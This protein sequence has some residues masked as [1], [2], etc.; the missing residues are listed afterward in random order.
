MRSCHG[1]LMYFRP[2]GHDCVTSSA[3]ALAVDARDE[4]LHVGE[5]ERRARIRIGDAHGVAR[6]GRASTSFEAALLPHGDV[7]TTRDEERAG[8]R[9]GVERRRAGGELRERLS[10][11]VADLHRVARDR[12]DRRTPPEQEDL[13]APDHRAQV[14]RRARRGAARS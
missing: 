7:A 2:F 14:E 5:A 9:V 8:R 10:R 1:L 6:E 12:T 3:G 13:G 4:R 11:R